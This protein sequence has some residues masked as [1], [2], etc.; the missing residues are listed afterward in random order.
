[1][2]TNTECVELIY[3]HDKYCVKVI[4]KTIKK[5][6]GDF[7]WSVFFILVDSVLSWI[8]ISKVILGFQNGS[9]SAFPRNE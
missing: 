8:L 2:L 7:F 6:L 4:F 9:K 3:D 5:P 1:M